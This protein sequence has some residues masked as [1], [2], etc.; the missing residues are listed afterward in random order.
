MLLLA[1]PCLTSTRS[2]RLPGTLVSKWNGLF[3]R[4]SDLAEDASSCLHLTFTSTVA[5][6]YMY[7]SHLYALPWHGDTLH[8]STGWS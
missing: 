2:E 6:Y 8:V 7:N 1:A 5:D 4:D 3:R